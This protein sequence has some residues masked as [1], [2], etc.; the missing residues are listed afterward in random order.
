MDE[1]YIL[2]HRQIRESSVWDT[3]E[4]FDRRSAWIDLLM[5]ANHKGK[6]IM[7]GSNGVDIKRGSLF[8][9]ENKLAERW[10]WGK[11]KVRIFLSFLEA[12]RMTAKIG[13]TQGT[14]LTI[15]NYDKFQIPGHT[16]G[17]TEEPRR[18]HAGT[19]R[20]NE[21]N[22]N[23]KDIYIRAREGVG[24][25][26]TCTTYGEYKNVRLTDEE[27]KKLN[28]DFGERDT[29][30]AIKF[31]DEYIEDKGYKTK[32]KTHYLAMRRWVYDAIGRRGKPRSPEPQK[33][34]QQKYEVTPELEKL[35]EEAWG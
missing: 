35:Y 5:M 8:T 29:E 23:E 19:E 15:V 13:T 16:Q 18:N 10:H 21:M 14:A 31:L 2:L 32:A 17:H 9:S 27:L 34:E 11:K 25:R 33:E 6:R 7:I 28:R 24:E 1:G 20:K 12:E 22:V 4:P 26:D 3:G 30:V